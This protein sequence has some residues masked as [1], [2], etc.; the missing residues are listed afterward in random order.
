MRETV[1]ELAGGVTEAIEIICDQVVDGLCLES[2]AVAFDG[3][4][5]RIE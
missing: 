2:F 4:S 5:I 1:T 3:L